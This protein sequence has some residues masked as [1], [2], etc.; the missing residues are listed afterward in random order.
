MA[1]LRISV[2]GLE[3]F[4]NFATVPWRDRIGSPDIS[5]GTQYA[6][7]STPLQFDFLST[8]SLRTFKARKIDN[9]GN[10]IYEYDLS[11]S[12][13]TATGTHYICSGTVDY[14]VALQCGLYYFIVND[15]YES[16]LFEVIELD[17]IVWIL[18]S[19]YWSNGGTAWT[20]DGIWNTL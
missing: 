10:T 3:F 1:N 4:D 6:E 7:N 19:G 8:E 5:F 16:E 15:R 2:S 18:D 13:I 12:L 9:L 14:T 20:S 17:N 11:T